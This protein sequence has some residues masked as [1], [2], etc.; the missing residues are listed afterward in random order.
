MQ[1]AV[2]CVACAL[3]SRSRFPWYLA[4]HSTR[5]VTCCRDLT[6]LFRVLLLLVQALGLYNGLLEGVRHK[7]DGGARTAEREQH[8]LA[9]SAERE[10]HQLQ[11]KAAEAAGRKVARMAN[12][13]GKEELEKKVAGRAHISH[14]NST[15]S[16]LL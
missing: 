3:F 5:T 11:L 8:L 2:S 14:A 6:Q 13:Q 4:P 1:L 7:A 9:L 15:A 16:C 10:A 12:M